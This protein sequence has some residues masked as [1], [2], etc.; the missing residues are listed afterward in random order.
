[1]RSSNKNHEFCLQADLKTV[2]DK[3]TV[4]LGHIKFY[5]KTV[6]LMMSRSKFAGLGSKIDQLLYADPAMCECLRQ[7]LIEAEE[8]GMSRIE[9]SLYDKWA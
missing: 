2:A 4:K 6:Q 1:V 5:C 3:E 7:D 9:L 8:R